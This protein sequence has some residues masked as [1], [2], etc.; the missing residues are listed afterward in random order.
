[1]EFNNP[2][3]IMNAKQIVKRLIEE[4]NPDYPLAIELV[5]K[6]WDGDVSPEQAFSGRENYLPEIEKTLAANPEIFKDGV[7][8]I[9][10]SP[11]YA[12]LLDSG[13][14]GACAIQSIVD[15]NE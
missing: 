8:F 6:I 10:D 1:M 15:D 4:V 7:P 9:E 2:K 14:V 13:D 5:Q 11:A 12:A 3:H